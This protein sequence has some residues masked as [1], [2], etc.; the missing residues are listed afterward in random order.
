MLKYI[1][2]LGFTPMAEKDTFKLTKQQ[3]NPWLSVKTV[4]GKQNRDM[5]LWLE[6]LETI[7]SV[8]F[9]PTWQGWEEEI[10]YTY[11]LF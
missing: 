2:I 3:E 11:S 8:Q 10:Y 4:S 5:D 7:M 1:E 6:L 9:L